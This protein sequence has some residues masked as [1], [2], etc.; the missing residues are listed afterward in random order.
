MNAAHLKKKYFKLFKLYQSDS[1]HVR[2]GIW[3]C[4]SRK[5]MSRV[6]ISVIN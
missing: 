5:Y 1:V 2:V 6:Y 4:V 3:T